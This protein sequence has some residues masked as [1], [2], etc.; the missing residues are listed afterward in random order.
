MANKAFPIEQTVI[1]LLLELMDTGFREP[2][3]NRP[4]LNSELRFDVY[5]KLK[6]FIKGLKIKYQIPQ[7][8]TTTRIAK[9]VN[10]V[11]SARKEKFKLNDTKEMT[12][13]EYFLKEKNY[14]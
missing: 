5:D 6:G 1:Q 3:D 13:E 8:A 14:R 2:R 4:A 9:V 7:K 10:V 12:V 11:G